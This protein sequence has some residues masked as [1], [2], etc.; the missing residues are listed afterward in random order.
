[1]TAAELLAVAAFEDCLYAQAFPSFGSERM[2]APVE[3][4]CRIDEKPIRT[5]EPVSRPDVL[6]VQDPTLIGQ[7]DIFK[8]VVV[9]AWVLVNATRP[10]SEL[11]LADLFARAP[12]ARIR[13]VPA[14]DLAL[15]HVGRPTPNSALLGG[16]VAL[17]GLMSLEGVRAALEHRFT[18]E[19]AAANVRAMEAAYEFVR[20]EGEVEARAATA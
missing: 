17:T 18:P 19:V 8:G 10:V 13:T 3:A 6:I 4:Y 5:R 11:D 9:D 2:G 14:T 7:V 20:A 1:M 16:L 12:R 15:A